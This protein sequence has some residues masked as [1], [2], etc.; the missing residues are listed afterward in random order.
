MRFLRYAPIGLLALV[1]GCF[2]HIKTSA[3]VMQSWIGHDATE[4]VSKWGV[5]DRSI[6]LADGKKAFTWI[7][8]RTTETAD[9]RSPTGSTRDLAEC[10]RTLTFAAD[11]KVIAWA[12][13]PNCPSFGRTR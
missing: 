12:L 1:S 8:L 5:P 13:S 7:D 4:V 9:V 11:G 10:R 2:L 6:D 3:S